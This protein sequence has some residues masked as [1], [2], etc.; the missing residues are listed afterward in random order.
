MISRVPSVRSRAADD[1]D[2][3]IELMPRGTYICRVVNIGNIEASHTHVGVFHVR[4]TL[5]VAEGEFAGRTLWEYVA[6]Y[7]AV[8][9]MLSTVKEHFIGKKYEVGVRIV[10]WRDKK[11]N[12]PSV[13]W[14]SQVE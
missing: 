2:D 4:I 10:D 7:M 1:A 6:G 14:G 3:D 8:V 9:I 13:R 5:E 12:A 11:F